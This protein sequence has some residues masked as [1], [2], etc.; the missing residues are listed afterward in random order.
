MVKLTNQEKERINN[1]I[2]NNMPTELPHVDLKAKRN[3]TIKRHFKSILDK[4]EDLVVFGYEGFS[5]T[6]AFYKLNNKLYVVT[7]DYN[8]VLKYALYVQGYEL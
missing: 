5:Y 6:N 4:N 1:F 3:K 8:D 2:G 7:F